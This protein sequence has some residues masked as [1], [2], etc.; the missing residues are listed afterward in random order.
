MLACPYDLAHWYTSLARGQCIFRTS[1][2]W[3]REAL[4]L[5]DCSGKRIWCVFVGNVRDLD[6]TPTLG[7]SLS[8]GEEATS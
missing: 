8:L 1:R 7:T 6:L 2:K 4:A 5:V 3:L